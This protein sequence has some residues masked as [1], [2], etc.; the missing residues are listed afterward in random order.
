MNSQGARQVEQA[1][2]P[3]AL[4]LFLAWW[5][6]VLYLAAAVSA[7]RAAGHACRLTSWLR[8]PGPVLPGGAG[9]ASKHLVGWAVDLVPKDKGN[10]AAWRGLAAFLRSWPFVYVL[11]H[12]GTARHLHVQIGRYPLKQQTQ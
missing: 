2:A 4:G 6:P 8:A 1:A 11:D 5:A 12:V 7:A 9:D 10:E 3:L